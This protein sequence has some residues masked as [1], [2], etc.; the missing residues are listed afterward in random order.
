MRSV[1]GR[2]NGKWQ[3]WVSNTECDD[4]A[5]NVRLAGIAIEHVVRQRKRYVHIVTVVSV[6]G[7]NDLWSSSIAYYSN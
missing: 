7:S 6:I 4:T 5:S 1:V 3:R 2:R